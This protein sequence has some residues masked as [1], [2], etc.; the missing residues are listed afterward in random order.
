LA[1]AKAEVEKAQAEVP[2]LQTAYNA[3]RERYNADVAARERAM[4]TTKSNTTEDGAGKKYMKK[5]KV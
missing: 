5:K 3:A 1:S 4:N 2:R